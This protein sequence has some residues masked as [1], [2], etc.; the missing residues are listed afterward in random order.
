MAESVL[1][2][3]TTKIPG[4]D[5][6]WYIDSAAIADWNVGLL[7]EPRCIEVLQENGLTSSHV[8]RQVSVSRLVPERNFE[9]CSIIMKYISCDSRLSST[10]I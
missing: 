1:K 10:T 3:L 4:I 5:L 8:A 7:P 2:N 6:N 9:C